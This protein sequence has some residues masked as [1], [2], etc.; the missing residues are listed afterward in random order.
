MASREVARSGLDPALGKQTSDRAHGDGLA[1]TGSL[2]VSRSS[3]YYSSFDNSSRS[4]RR[5]NKTTL[6][7]KKRAKMQKRYLGMV[8]QD[9][10]E[11]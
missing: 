11:K 10:R 8:L 7:K 6:I 3:R 9:D 5:L 4:S 2:R 1:I